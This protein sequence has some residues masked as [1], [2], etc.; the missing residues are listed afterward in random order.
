MA[1]ADST[2]SLCRCPMIF[3]VTQIWRGLSMSK[4]ELSRRK[5]MQGLA[6]ALPAGTAILHGPLRAE[7]LPQL[8][9]DDP[10]A[11]ALLYVHDAAN[12]DTS[13]PLAARFEAGQDCANCA[14]IQGEEGA[15]WRPCGIFPGKLV[16]AGGWCS[17]WVPKP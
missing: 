10:A 3:R 9:E 14:Q 4:K 2:G 5:F 17:V 8:S 6:V 13:N 7:D 16:A 15:E 1:P 12:V 11:K